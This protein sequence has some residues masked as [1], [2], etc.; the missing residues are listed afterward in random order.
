MYY[1]N[2][3]VGGGQPRGQVAVSYV[4][5]SLLMLHLYGQA[6]QL[7]EGAG[8]IHEPLRVH[9][10]EV[11]RASRSQPYLGGVHRA[12]VQHLPVNILR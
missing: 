8:G 10:D 1:T 9:G 3:R 12:H 7:V 6:P 11:G 2:F 5:A 4:I